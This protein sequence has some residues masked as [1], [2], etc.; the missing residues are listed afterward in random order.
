MTE[1]T[2]LTVELDFTPY[3]SRRTSYNPETDEEYTEQVT[4]EG[5]IVDRIAR[6]LYETAIASASKGEDRYGYWGL[7]YKVQEITEEVIRENVTALVL[8]ELEKALAPTC[9]DDPDAPPKTLKDRIVELAK[10][11]L[12]L[13]EPNNNYNGSRQKGSLLYEAVMAATSREINKEL[14]EA[15]NAGKEQVKKALRDTGAQLLADTL[16]AQAAGR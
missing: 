11:Q 10:D 4:F 14:G 2:T 1:P 7:K 8:A 9:S 6:Q 3:L 5:L 16:A 15:L 13:R 12:T